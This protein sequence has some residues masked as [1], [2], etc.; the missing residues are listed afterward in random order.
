MV[1]KKI[2]EY[3]YWMQSIN[4]GFYHTLALHCVVGVGKDSGTIGVGKN[5]GM[6]GVG[7]DLDMVHE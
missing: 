3:D 1:Y 5:L 2:F 6:M 7:K 4:K